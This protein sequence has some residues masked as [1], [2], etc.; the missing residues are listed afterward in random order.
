MHLFTLTTAISLVLSLFG[1]MFPLILQRHTDPAAN[2]RDSI[3][4]FTCRFYR[5]AQSFNDD[6]ADLNVPVIQ[7]GVSWPRG[8][9]RVCMESEAATG[10]V[11]ALLGLSVLGLAVGLWGMKE[12]KQIGKARERRWDMKWSS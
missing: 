10:L 1:T 4:S 8:F 7:G 9:R 2:H 5:R 11:A 3:Q 6:M 12:A